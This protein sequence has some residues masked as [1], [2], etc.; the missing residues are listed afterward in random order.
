MKPKTK[1]VKN[2]IILGAH[3]GHWTYRMSLER[4]FLQCMYKCVCVYL[5]DCTEASVYCARICLLTLL[6]QG[7]GLHSVP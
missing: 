5:H 2:L 7:L 1:Q 4:A 6:E 3:W